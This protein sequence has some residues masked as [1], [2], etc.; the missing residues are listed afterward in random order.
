VTYGA[1]PALA[2]M[3]VPHEMREKYSSQNGSVVEGRAVYA[4]FRRYSVNVDEKVKK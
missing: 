3:L 1:E 4:K 2:G